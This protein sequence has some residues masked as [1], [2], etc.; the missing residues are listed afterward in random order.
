MNKNSVYSCPACN[1]LH[2]Q[3]LEETTLIACKN[4]G[5]IIFQSITGDTK[6]KPSKIPQDWSFI[7]IGASGLYQKRPFTIIGR[8]RLQLRNDYKNFWC[9]EISNGKSQWIMESFGS[10]SMLNPP[11]HEYT[12]SASKLRAGKSI[13]VAPNLHY[14]GE[15]VEK[16][17]GMSYE[18]EIGSWKLFAPGFFL[19][20]ASRN[21]LQT[22]IF[23]IESKDHVE[24]ITGSLVKVE[25]LSLKNILEW[26]EWK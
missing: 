5:E 2:T 23:T 26:N 6:I 17:E 14:N 22:C 15:Y 11:W 3:A 25:D 13:E 12:K 21:D 16:C 9:A 18:G 7:K 4:C 19:V 24:Y 8:I 1:T 20:Q 10:F